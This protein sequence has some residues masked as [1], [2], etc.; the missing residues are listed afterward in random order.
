MSDQKII[1]WTDPDEDERITLEYIQ[2]VARK[3]VDYIETLEAE[4]DRLREALQEAYNLRDKYAKKLEA[5][6]ARLR[7]LVA[8]AYDEGTCAGFRHD[9]ER[10]REA[11]FG[12]VG[13]V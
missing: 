7:Q 5:E 11:V 1:D 8:D 12:R 3:A 13:A 9:C 10:N 6:N 2:T 4:R